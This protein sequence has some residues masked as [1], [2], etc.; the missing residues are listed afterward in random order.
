MS[1][2]ASSEPSREV[3]ARTLLAVCL[4][5]LLALANQGLLLATDPWLCVEQHRWISFAIPIGCLILVA[6]FTAGAHRS[7]RRERNASQADARS[8]ERFLSLL[9]MALGALAATLIVAQWAAAFTFP[10]CSAI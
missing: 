10:P 2:R 6:V 5:P 4:N 3:S 7:W 1:A 9:G 8:A